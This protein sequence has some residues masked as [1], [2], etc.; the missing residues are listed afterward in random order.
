MVKLVFIV[1]LVL[2]FCTTNGTGLCS[3]SKQKTTSPQQTDSSVCLKS[4]PDYNEDECELDKQDKKTALAD[5]QLNIIYKKITSN[6]GAK[7]KKELVAA[8]RLWLQFHKKTVIFKI[9][10]LRVVRQLGIA[11]SFLAA[12]KTISKQE[13]S[14]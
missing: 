10:L 9:Q 8:Q 4:S 1:T 2:S 11:L 3:S 14:N 12:S 5:K 7:E 6:L 13:S